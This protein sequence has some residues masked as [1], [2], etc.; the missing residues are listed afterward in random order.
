MAWSEGEKTRESEEGRKV[1]RRL[2]I[3]VPPSQSGK[4]EKSERTLYNPTADGRPKRL[5]GDSP[6]AWGRGQQ[7]V[8]SIN[9]PG[10]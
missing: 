4:T 10:N 7:R 1:E 3:R 5:A 9:C 2:T 8:G 6:T